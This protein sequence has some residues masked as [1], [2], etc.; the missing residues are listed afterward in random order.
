MSI[1]W[2]G[3]IYFAPWGN[4]NQKVYRYL[5]LLFL[6]HM[7]A[8]CA[9]ESAAVLLHYIF[10]MKKRL[11]ALMLLML[12]ARISEGYTHSNNI[13]IF[14]LTKCRP[15]HNNITREYVLLLLFLIGY[16]IWDFCHLYS[17][18]FFSAL[19]F[20]LFQIVSAYN[21]NNNKK[22][23]LAPLMTF[24]RKSIR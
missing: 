1:V 24:E 19:F 6:W 10:M 16:L 7:C 8:C 4:K 21:N 5:A 3:V 11:C 9:A 12:R 20:S 18:D 23:P 2:L 17:L 13:N 15:S 14:L 22:T